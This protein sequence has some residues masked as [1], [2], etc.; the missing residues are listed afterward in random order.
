MIKVTSFFNPRHYLV[1]DR[2]EKDGVVTVHSSILV[3][4]TPEGLWCMHCSCGDCRHVR[5]VIHSELE[6]V[7]AAVL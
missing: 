3:L 1:E 4:E 6:R 2:R 5:S 7:T